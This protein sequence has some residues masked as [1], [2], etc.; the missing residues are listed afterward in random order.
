M[1]DVRASY[2]N[3][4]DSRL[5]LPLLPQDRRE[6]LEALSP[7]GEIRG[8]GVTVSGLDE[9][10]PAFRLEAD[11]DDVGIAADGKRPGVRGFT[12]YINGDRAGGRLEL[13]SRNMLVELPEVMAEA[14][15]IAMASG[16]LLWRQSG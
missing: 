12:G 7:S 4:D 14:I 2:L 16:T 1:L 9:A 8:L 13:R 10:S 11:L 3:L 15:D 6:Q 5:L